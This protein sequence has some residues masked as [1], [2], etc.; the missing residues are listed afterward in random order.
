MQ[1]VN[2][3]KKAHELRTAALDS[4][5]AYRPT[6]VSAADQ[7]RNLQKIRFAKEEVDRLL[8]HQEAM[9]EKKRERVGGFEWV[10]EN[11]I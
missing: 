10:D 9:E 11:N 7:E 4:D 3:Q 5:E 6:F 8:M 2:E 1:S